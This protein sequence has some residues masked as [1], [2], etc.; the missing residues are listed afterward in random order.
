M[1]RMRDL[2]TLSIIMDVSVKCLPQGSGNL[3]IIE[4]ERV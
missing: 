1:Q 2:G 4:V 3:E